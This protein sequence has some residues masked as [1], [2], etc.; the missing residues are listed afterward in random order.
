M[1]GWE[2]LGEDG[3]RVYTNRAEYEADRLVVTSGAWNDQM[4]PFLKG[5]AVPERQV[6]AWLQPNKP[7]YFK[8]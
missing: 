3:V 2:A 5:L 6:L 7:E 8:P 4:M 1:L